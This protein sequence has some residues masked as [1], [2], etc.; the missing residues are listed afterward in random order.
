MSKLAYFVLGGPGSG[1][2]TFCEKLVKAVH[3]KAVHFSAGE[4]LRQFMSQNAKLI[5]DPVALK[6]YQTI[7]NCIRE[8]LI[9]PAEITVGLLLGATD[10]SSNKYILIDGFPRNADNYNTWSRMASFHREIA[11][12][13]L[14]FL[15]CQ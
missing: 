3:G 12:K 11:T 15:K 8:G 9:V 10:K 6:T 14:I 4:L 13:K 1:K 2:G 7:D 5:N